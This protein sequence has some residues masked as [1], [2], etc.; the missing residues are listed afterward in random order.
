MIIQD[1]HIQSK[2]AQD[3]A[4]PAARQG[5]LG[6]GETALAAPYSL[7]L[8]NDEYE[9]SFCYAAQFVKSGGPIDKA[10]KLI[11][12]DDISVAETDVATSPLFTTA[13]LSFATLVYG[14]RQSRPSVIKKG[15]T[16]H[17]ATL[18]KLNTALSGQISCIDDE[19]LL[20]ICALALLETLVPTH[21]KSYLDHML[22]LQRL[23]ELRGPNRQASPAACDIYMH[24]R[25]M[26]IFASVRARCPSVFAQ[27]EWKALLRAHCS[28]EQLWEQ[29]LWD[30]LADCTVLFAKAQQHRVASPSRLMRTKKEAVILLDR[31]HDWRRLWNEEKQYSYLEDTSPLAGLQSA[32][33]EFTDGP[34]P[35]PPLRPLNFVNDNAASLLLLYDAIL[36][37]VSR[38]L[39]ALYTPNEQR[40]ETDSVP[41]HSSGEDT[42]EDSNSSKMQYGSE[43]VFAALEV[44]CCIPYS[45]SRGPYY[46]CNNT[47]TP[48]IHWAVATAW[49][50]LGR[51]ESTVGRWITDTLGMQGSNYVAQGLWE[52]PEQP[53]SVANAPLSNDLIGIRKGSS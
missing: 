49:M 42:A 19:V 15:L 2:Q 25:H 17:G 10:R 36:I 22:G 53:D 23:L 40:R 37:S 45:I 6:D 18:Q 29:D 13:Y 33:A 34:G 20:S 48:N 14:R 43:E 4:R 1:R 7:S 12:L 41:D 5:N 21:P 46:N 52:V 31:L 50:M 39:V 32:L 51:N 38:L 9:L 16:M 35:D 27:P 47:L 44:C 24:I 8:K 3:S 30:V 28:R 26:L 11:G